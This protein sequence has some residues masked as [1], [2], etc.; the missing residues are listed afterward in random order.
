VAL[1]LEETESRPPPRAVVRR[2]RPWVNAAIGLAV[3]IAL[4]FVLFSRAWVSPQTTA[5]GLGTDPVF[6]IWFLRWV[7]FALGHGWNPLL[8]TYLDY[9]AGANLS[10]SGLFPL[11]A[12]VLSP[13]TLWLGPV[14]AYNLLATLALALSAWAGFF[15]ARRFVSSPFAAALAGL[16]Y[17]F[18]PALI[19]QSLGHPQIAVAFIPPL[20]LLALD[21]ILVRQRWTYLRS[22][23][24]LGLLGAAQLL[25]G[26]ELLA[27]EV[28]VGA[29]G[30]ALLMAAKRNE[31]ASHLGYAM[32]AAGVA[33]VV[34]LALVVGPLASQFF[35]PQRVVGSL[36]PANVYVSDLL[37]FIVPTSVQ[38]FAPGVALRLSEQFSGSL[39]EWNAYLGVPL[40]ALLV[41][42]AIRYRADL[43]VRLC[44]LL[45][46]LFALL[47]LGITLHVG[48]HVTPV[49]VVLLAISFV[50]LRGWIPLRAILYTFIGLW[51]GLAIVPVVSNILPG[52]LM[53]FVFLFAGI[54]LAGFVDHALRWAN[55]RHRALAL[56]AVGLA[57]LP[58]VPRTPYPAT[59]MSTP[60]FFTG[61]LGSLVPNGSVTLVAPY[62]RGGN[63]EGMLWQAQSGMA[64]KM[65]EGYA[66]IPG[67]RANP[68]D[69]VLG[70]EM[71]AIEHGAAPDLNPDSLDR[72]R[73]DLNAWAVTTVVIGPMPHR[74]T[75]VALFTELLGRAPMTRAGV[76]L[77]T[78]V[79]AS[80][81]QQ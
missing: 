22:G 38:Q 10:W 44:A 41:V 40:L 39:A 27:A 75:V 64:F 17:G 30:T 19:A 15:A 63:T 36:Q 12:L 33:A 78:G 4:A 43:M 11:P 25:T 74:V 13:V 76:Q 45:A 31:I 73:A 35:G 37:N 77:W 55:G 58:L 3:Y 2:P 81:P 54:L 53:L 50:G 51:A 1:R 6:S 60:A 47:S 29:A 20:M 16:L 67:P 70:S 66:L 57:L 46:F 8:T 23:A 42:A 79:S 69:S 71:V 68:P 26:E 18:S 80:S 32:R 7:P 24:L 65:P 62:V 5:V 49:P 72:M 56:A 34:F 52:R 9:P 61:A 48:G 59:A 21:E 14:V 28:I